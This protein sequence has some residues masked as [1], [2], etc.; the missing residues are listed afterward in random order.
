MGSNDYNWHLVLS[1][2]HDPKDRLKHLIFTSHYSLTNA[3][4]NKEVEKDL[5]VGT[6]DKFRPLKFLTNYQ[7][8]F[9]VN[10]KIKGL[11]AVCWNQKWEPVSSLDSWQHSGFYNFSRDWKSTI[12]SLNFFH[13]SLFFVMIAMVRLGSSH[14]T[15]LLEHLDL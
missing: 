14:C 8:E 5:F 3:T 10:G 12:F 6:F 15:E 11:N 2:V 7:V 9:M 13:G 1:E 4:A